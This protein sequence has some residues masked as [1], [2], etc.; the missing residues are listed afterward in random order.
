MESG[1]RWRA[2]SWGYSGT[3]AGQKSV[4][5]APRITATIGVG[6]E[7]RGRER[8]E[9]AESRH[10][11]RFVRGLVALAPLPQAG[12]AT[13]IGETFVPLTGCG[14]STR[15]QT[16]SPS[17]QYAAPFAGVITSWSFQSDP[18]PPT[19]KFKVGRGAGGNNFTVV[20][21]SPLLIPAPSFLNTNPVRIPVQAGDVIGIYLDT[22]GNCAAS[23]ATGYTNAFLGGDQLPGST[24]TYAQETNVKNDVSATLEP[25]ADQ[26]GFGDETQDK[27]VGTAGSANGCPSTVTI[28]KLQQKGLPGSGHAR[29]PKVNVTATV[30]GAGTLSAGSPSDPILAAAAAKSLKPVTTTVTATTKQQVVLTLN[31]TKGAKKKLSKHGKLKLQV[32]VVYT[33]VGGPPGSQTKKVKLKS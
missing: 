30:P 22:F 15:L 21:E 14:T 11:V 17:A 16:R 8:E 1:T 28:D 33:P 3:G 5:R 2:S 23:S 27:C 18:A 32:K 26:D 19:I 10:A 13:Q 7:T 20:G 9:H 29:K 4:L 25:D 12:A 6:K 31:L 24:G